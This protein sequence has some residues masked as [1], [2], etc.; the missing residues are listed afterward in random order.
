[1]RVTEPDSPMRNAMFVTPAS[2]FSCE[3]ACAGKRAFRRRNS[4]ELWRGRSVK[5]P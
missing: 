1:L 3:G 4:G 2:V 5:N